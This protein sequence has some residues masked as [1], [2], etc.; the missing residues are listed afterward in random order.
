M[1][2]Q[3]KGEGCGD[4]DAQW[5]LRPGELTTTPPPRS[6]A[7]GSLELHAGRHGQRADGSDGE[8]SRGGGQRPIHGLRSA[9]VDTA[10]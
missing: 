4:G 9:S 1:P 2:R 5:R 3:R 6:T 8:Q 7:V 10:A